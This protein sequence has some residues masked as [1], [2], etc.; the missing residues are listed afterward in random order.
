MLKSAYIS[1][2]A[3]VLG[4]RSD[5]LLISKNNKEVLT[6]NKKIY[7]RIKIEFKTKDKNSLCVRWLNSKELFKKC[8]LFAR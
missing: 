4:I 3:I 7:N 1:A 6:Y 8:K 5:K 2:I